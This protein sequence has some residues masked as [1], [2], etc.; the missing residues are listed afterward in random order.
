MKYSITKSTKTLVVTLDTESG[1]YAPRV[2][3][4][5]DPNVILG[6][7]DICLLENGEPLMYL[8]NHEIGLIDG[9][10]AT[11][12]LDAVSKIEAVIN[13]LK[14]SVSPKFK[15]SVVP[16]DTPQG[17]DDAFWIAT[18]AGTYTQFGNF[19]LPANTRAEISRVNGVFSVSMTALDITSKVNVSDIADNLTTD[20]GSVPASARQVKIL[21]EKSVK[22]PDPNF[23]NYSISWIVGSYYDING[24]VVDQSGYNRSAQL[25]IT[26]TAFSIS[27]PSYQGTGSLT[28]VLYFK[29]DGTFLSKDNNLVA[30][31]EYVDK[32]LLPPANAKFVAFNQNAGSSIR[33]LT[34]KSSS[35]IDVSELS[36]FILPLYSAKAKKPV[37][38]YFIDYNLFAK[39]NLKKW[40]D[41]DYNGLAKTE[42]TVS[43]NG[44][45][46]AYGLGKELKVT[47]AG[48]QR[49]IALHYFS[50]PRVELKTSNRINYHFYAVAPVSGTYS[51]EIY[52]LS[53]SV[54][55]V[56]MVLVANVIKEV[57]FSYDFPNGYDWT[58]FQRLIL[59]S[60]NHLATST[61][62][63]SPLEIW[64]GFLPQQAFSNQISLKEA[65]ILKDRSGFTGA[66]GLFIGDSISTENEYFWKGILSS[67][68]GFDYVPAIVGQLAPAQGGMKLYPPIAETTSSESIWYRCGGNR[69]AIYSFDKITL[70]GGTNDLDSGYDLGASTDTAYKDTDSR[71]VNL[72]WCAVLKGCI[73][74]LQRDFPTVEIVL[75]TVMDISSRGNTMYDATY[76]TRESMA[77]K[78][79]QVASVYNL[80]CV[81]FFWNSGLTSR[82]TSIMTSD[83]THPNIAGAKGMVACYADTVGL[84]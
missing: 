53:T 67:H 80:K 22:V 83:N 11:S 14:L 44:Y 36:T 6:N 77:R 35:K 47:N 29:A 74:M 52:N 63:M 48:V 45:F 12:L 69:M 72:T 24:A 43:E 38:N 71:P 4:F 17:T 49:N 39:N 50:T 56:P 76:N 2:T 46:S 21:N 25:D 55:V 18:Q 13:S 65:N 20:S 3:T 26:N 9:I 51:I 30:N 59:Y 23:I 62:Y 37:Y 84:R 57:S 28:S 78:T 54:K 82:N 75:C 34:A 68:Y 58:T 5:N 15:G 41:G 66:R 31:T 1:K 60:I 70:F 81:P 79:M 8:Q 40:K 61:F 19:V 27:I 33:L 16:T 7:N 10:S 32:L 42:I 73:E 64:D